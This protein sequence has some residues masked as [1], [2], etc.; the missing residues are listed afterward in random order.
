MADSGAIEK[1]G[2][3]VAAAIESDSELNAI[4]AV[5]S[6]LVPLKREG[7]LRV[8]DYVLGRLGMT[9][10]VVQQ[11]ST[12]GLT[13]DTALRKT[14]DISDSLATPSTQANDIRSL[15]K[16]KSPRS[17]NEMAALVAYYLSER[18][19]EPYRKLA[20]TTDDI[21]SYF[22]QAPF[23]LPQSPQQTLINAKNS[24][25]LESAGTGQYRLNPVGYN[26]VVHGLPAGNS[27]KK[28]IKIKKPNLKKASRKGK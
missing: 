4:R 14:P 27:G 16:V 28:K 17:A 22:K 12:G 7:R 21:K 18:A 25:Y 24:G 9:E 10:P 11:P 15:T 20:I 6:A 1:S 23:R 19:P 2:E 13:A 26:L 3:L 8:L 5:L